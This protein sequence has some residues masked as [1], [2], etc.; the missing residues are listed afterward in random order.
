[1]GAAIG[2]AFGPRARVTAIGLMGWLGVAGMAMAWQ[3]PGEPLGQF[4]PQP[5]GAQVLTRGPIHEAFAE[6]LV[7][8]PAPN[9]VIQ[10][11]PPRTIIDEI[12]PAQKP[13]GADVEW[14]PGY[15][16]WDDERNNY[17]WISG[18]WR[19]IP[20]GRQW[21]PGYWSQGDTGFAWTSGFWAPT[22]GNGQFNY[23]PAPPPTQEA[24]PTSPQP[25]AN[26]AWA[27]GSWAWAENRYDWRPGYWFQAQQ[28]WV[29]VP[30]TYVP[31]PSG[32]VYNDGYWDYSLARRGLPFAPVAFAPSVYGQQ[33]YSYTPNYVLPVA[34]L[35][36]SL[37]VRPSY[38][39]YYYGDYYQSSSLGA[40][41]GYVPWF[42]L[43]QD[44]I[45][46]DPFYGSMSALNSGRPEWDRQIRDDYRDR[47]QNP[48]ARPPA[49]FAGQ[50][51]LLDQRQA[52]GED[53][54][55]HGFVQ[56]LNQWA[57]NN[58]ANH[59]IVPVGEDHQ[60]ELRRRQAD[61]QGL[62]EQRSRLESQAR[63]QPNVRPQEHPPQRLEMP[64]SPV[65][66]ASAPRIQGQALAAPPPHP[67]PAQHPNFQPTF[68]RE[69]ATIRLNPSQGNREPG[70]IEPPRQPGQPPRIE[71]PRPPPQ[72][73]PPRPPVRVEPPRE[74]RPPQ[75]EPKGEPKGKPGGPR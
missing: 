36:S 48:S 30:S 46:Y 51:A 27:P 37:F 70:R 25:G 69:P 2:W 28:D 23:L 7:Y 29:W 60:A 75:G 17:I 9:V 59:R 16:G 5:G 61:L 12:P 64:R 63:M 21:V 41:S 38:G 74:P 43:Q 18:I 8:N 14:I 34:G 72:V 33:S 40:R 44:R 26:F 11:P 15:W 13:Y 39:H 31:T 24:G 10:S 56:P 49:T 20:P 66:A 68:A 52:R 6:P 45:G 42:G 1:M 65:V 57:A 67:A 71:A 47:I 55:N 35:L 54:R 3:V 19:D 53:S 62:R 22:A 32:Y 4:D 73:E 58:Q 50:R